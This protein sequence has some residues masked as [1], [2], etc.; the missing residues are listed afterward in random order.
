MYRYIL[1]VWA[2]AITCVIQN[3]R[4]HENL[5]LTSICNKIWDVEVWSE[6]A[7]ER[8]RERAEEGGDPM[9]GKSEKQRRGFWR[10]LNRVTVLWEW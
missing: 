1:D 10:F 7:G 6:F 3:D 4:T 2:H 8:E 9:K 5:E